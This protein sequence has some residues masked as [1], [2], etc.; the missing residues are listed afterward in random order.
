[1]KY[2]FLLPVFTII[3]CLCAP[4]RAQESDLT[5]YF[6]DDGGLDLGYPASWDEPLPVEDGRILKL[7]MAQILVDSP[8]IRPP[9]VPIITI[10]LYSE[11]MPDSDL[12][13][14]LVD[15]LGNIDITANPENAVDVTL[16]GLDALEMDG[17]SS[18]ELLA[19]IGRA[20]L[21]SDTTALV[22][23]GR[24][25]SEQSDAFLKV[26]GQVVESI[27][28]ADTEIMTESETYG[29]LW[30]TMRTV[31]DG[32]A[33]F[34]NLIGL[35]YSDGKLYTIERDLGVIQIDAATGEILE[36]LPVP[37]V[38][39]PTD[40]AVDTGTIYIAD[41]L[42][43][44]IFTLDENGESQIEGFNDGA[45]I[46]ILADNGKLYAT[47]IENDNTISIRVFENGELTNTIPL[48]K[49]LFVQPILSIDSLG[50]VL[51]LTQY[52]EIIRLADDRSTPLYTLGP[53]SDSLTDMAVDS[54]NHFV[55]T[56]IDQGISILDS[57]GEEVGRP[58]RIVP[59]FPLPGEVVSPGGVA[60]GTDGTFYFID[61][62]GSFGAITAMRA[63]IPANRV[64]A[65]ELQLNRAVQGTL[66]S[67]ITR[68]TWTFAG[69]A[70]QYITISVIGSSD[71]LGLVVHLI[72][73]DGAE[74]AYSDTEIVDLML[75]SDGTYIIIVERIDGTGAYS[76]GISETQPID[77]DPNGVAKLEGRL[78]DMFSTQRWSFEGQAG[79]SFTLTMQASTLDPILRLVDSNGDVLDE[80]DDT[81]DPAL[82]SAAQI[83]NAQLPQNGRYVIEATSFEGEGTYELVIV[84]T[85]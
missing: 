71:E 70:E 60:V 81:G 50:R 59:N 8:D 74:T 7:Q 64:G 16:A 58:G 15:A 69:K 84:R 39:D 24:A 72:T 34:L 42:C 77:F 20:A 36:I 66:S 63:G 38:S 80:N 1:M 26:F 22:V 49:N 19:G 48:N 51:I 31:S 6:W 65:P 44:C 83:S 30:Q 79:Q 5:R 47:N 75:E 12:E 11:L 18:D 55:I 35:A 57:N 17:M 52:G 14:L 3:L 61:S 32:D 82:G 46:S 73:P 67:Q 13:S 33:A 27:K 53:M 41:I 54:N 62:D 2:Q 76:L 78:D 43:S 28:I 23:T 10:L 45:P 21:I 40:I 56:T 29:V 25:I 9:G 68:Q 85:G 37:H 4:L